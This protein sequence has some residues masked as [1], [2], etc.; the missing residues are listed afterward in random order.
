LGDWEVGFKGVRDCN[1]GKESGLRYIRKYMIN[2]SEVLKMVI[3]RLDSSAIPYMVSG[4]IAANFYTTPRMTRDIDIVIEVE[5]EDAQKLFS[6][7]SDDFYIDIESVKRAIRDEHMFNI[8][9]N[10]AIIKVDFIIRKETDYRKIEF[11]RRRSIF[12]EGLKIYITSPEDLIVSKLFWAKDSFSEMQI[13][14]VK[15][16]MNTLPELDREYIEKWIQQLRIEEIYN[17]VNK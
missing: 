17:R 9:H 15:N 4:S 16:L 14:D 12:F 11:K 6:L 8:I 10:E 3:T 2:E 7:F 1:Q 5:K 13:R